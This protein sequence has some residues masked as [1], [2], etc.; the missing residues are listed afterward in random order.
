LDNNC[1]RNPDNKRKPW[2]FTTDSETR[3]E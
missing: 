3:W 2:C 1:C